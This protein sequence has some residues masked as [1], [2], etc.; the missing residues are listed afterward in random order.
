[1]IDASPETDAAR[2]KRRLRWEIFRGQDHVGEPM[3]LP[4]SPPISFAELLLAGPECRVAD[5]APDD[6]GR[7]TGE[8][9]EQ[10]ELSVVRP[11]APAVVPRQ[12]ADCR[13]HST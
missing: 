11:M 3:L 7:L 12:H 5:R 6:V 9:V 8:E 2:V 10:A 1:M 4:A 13:P